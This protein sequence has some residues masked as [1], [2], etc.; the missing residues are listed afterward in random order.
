MHKFIIMILA[1]TAVL[2]TEWTW[3][4]MA[5]DKRLSNS[6]RIEQIKERVLHDLP[7]GTPLLQIDKY[8]TE[9]GVEHGYYKKPNRVLAMLNHIKRGTVVH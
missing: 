4:A 2:S 3:N 5:S 8:F 9:N 6:L 1:L 7:P